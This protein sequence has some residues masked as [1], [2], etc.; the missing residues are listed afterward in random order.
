MYEVNTPEEYMHLLEQ[1][2]YEVDDLMR[3]AE[4]EGEVDLELTGQ[5]ASLKAM[6]Q[7]LVQLAE[8][9]ASGNHEFGKGK[10]LPFMEQV[11]RAQYLPFR[12]MLDALNAAYRKG[13]DPE[14]N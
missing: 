9:L 5:L 8:Q 6:R 13:F 3:C 4:D 10:E 14:K 1:T 2:I 7:G 12:P 11:R